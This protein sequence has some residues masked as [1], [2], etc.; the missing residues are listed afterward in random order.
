[1]TTNTDFKIIAYLTDKIIL[2]RIVYQQ[3]THINYAFAIP[4]SDG[5]L[6]PLKSPEKLH[7]IVAQ[8][9][10]HNVKVLI[11]V[12]GWGW[13]KEFEALAA[14]Q[15]SRATHIRA[16]VSLVDKYQLDGVDMDWEYPQA[17]ESSKNFLALM[18]E[19]RTALP[20]D[21]L[22]TM[23]VVSYG[24]RNGLGIPAESI[25]LVDFVNLMTYDD[26]DHGTLEQFEKGLAYWSARGV[27]A[28]KLIMGMPFYS[29]P[30][31]RAY[32]ELVKLDSSAP[33][34]DR[35]RVAGVEEHY[36]GIPTTQT[37][38]RI[39]KQKAG[40]MMFWTLDSDAP[41]ES[42]LLKAIYVTAHA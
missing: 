40:G 11:S 23:A 19:L 34:T 2:E 15:A 18:T 10:K 41:G 8:A 28:N 22:L 42:S 24:D 37:K 1:M 35:I 29:R 14:T 7:T 12:G 25:E 33:N 4:N 36:N 20:K 6:Q 17:G 13:E 16:L 30:G 21:K 31:A 32:N 26:V 3:L 5:T 39:A 27:P 9:H 38:T